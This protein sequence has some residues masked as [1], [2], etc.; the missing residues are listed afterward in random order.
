MFSDFFSSVVILLKK[1][2]KPFAIF[3][4]S[5]VM[6]SSKFVACDVE[7]PSPPVVGNIDLIAFQKRFG[8]FLFSVS[9][10]L[11]YDCLALSMRRFTRFRNLLYVDQSISVFVLLAFLR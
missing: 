4:V 2:P 3:V 6:Q 9:R 11:L 5:V 7:L 10:F 8:S 1:N